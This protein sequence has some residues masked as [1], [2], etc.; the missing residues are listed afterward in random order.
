VLP[1]E[2]E[3][4]LLGSA[5]LGAVAGGTYPSVAAAMAAMTR[6]GAVVEPAA[7]ARR[8]HAAKHAVFLRM[9]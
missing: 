7:N 4:V 8:F 5:L 1:R 9:H 6:A 2:L 3:A